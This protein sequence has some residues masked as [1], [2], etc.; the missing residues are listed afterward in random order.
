MANSN[1][2]G[3]APANFHLV[4]LREWDQNKNAF[5][6]PIRTEKLEGALKELASL[7]QERVRTRDGRERDKES[8]LTWVHITSNDMLLCQAST[9]GLHR[10]ILLIASSRT[11]WEGSARGHNST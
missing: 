5:L 4:K 11:C 1:E 10:S 2:G 6:E 8:K 7:R 9:L 3:A